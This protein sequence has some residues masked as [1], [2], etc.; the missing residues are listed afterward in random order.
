MID[1]SYTIKRAV[2]ITSYLEEKEAVEQLV[3]TGTR[4]D[5]AVFAVIAARQM[6]RNGRDKGRSR[7]QSIRLALIQI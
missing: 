6:T 2:T 4:P 5:V 1:F 3:S 7:Q